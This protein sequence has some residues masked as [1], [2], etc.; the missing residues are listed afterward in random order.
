M[1]PLFTPLF[2]SRASKTATAAGSLVELFHLYPFRLLVFADH[3]LR[4]PF[5]MIYNYRFIGEI[6]K[7]H[8]N[9]SPVVRIYSPGAVQ[10]SYALLIASYYILLA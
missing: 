4:D 9:F 1:R 7:N 6:N 2:H 8:A 5:S 10:D 3:H